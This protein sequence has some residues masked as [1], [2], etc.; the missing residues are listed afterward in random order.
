MGHD[1]AM[2]VD[3]NDV[4]VAIH[5]DVQALGGGLGDGEGRGCQSQCQGE[6]DERGPHVAWKCWVYVRK[7]VGEVEYEKTNWM[8]LSLILSIWQA[9]KQWNI[10]LMKWDFGVLVIHH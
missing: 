10:L 3:G 1:G 9:D 8:G 7:E 2:T 5:G 6:Q 4:D